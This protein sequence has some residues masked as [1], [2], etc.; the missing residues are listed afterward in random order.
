MSPRDEG[1]RQELLERIDDLEHRNEQLE[2][3]LAHTIQERNMLET[4][5]RNL[6]DTCFKSPHLAVAYGPDKFLPFAIA[7]G[8]LK[9]LRHLRER[10]THERPEVSRRAPGP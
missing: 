10:R 2:T 7:Y 1:S 5:M 9:S 6:R 8:S 3:E 4:A